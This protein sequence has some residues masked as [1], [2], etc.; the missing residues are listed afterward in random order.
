MPCWASFSLL[1]ATIASKTHAAGGD[2]RHRPGGPA[3]GGEL[4]L[5]SDREK[6]VTRTNGLV[7]SV[8]KRDWDRMKTYLHPNVSLTVF[9][10][11][12]RW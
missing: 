6:A 5:D 1:P 9:N 11:A 2:H 7:E 12:M 4:L 8:E 10:G 3:G